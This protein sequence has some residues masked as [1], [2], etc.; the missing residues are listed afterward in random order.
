MAMT[1]GR[2]LVGREEKELVTELVAGT[3]ARRPDGAAGTGRGSG[4][5]RSRNA[6][7]TLH[8]PRLIQEAMFID[9]KAELGE[10]MLPEMLSPPLLAN[11]NPPLATTGGGS[12]V[13]L[14]FP[15]PSCDDRDVITTLIPRQPP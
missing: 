15:A 1:D 3:P 8:C 9:P 13:R 14:E 2:T 4:H 12:S 7:S 10:T 5:H 11:E 6:R